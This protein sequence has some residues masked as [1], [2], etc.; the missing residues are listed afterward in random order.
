VT[1]L[2]NRFEITAIPPR[3]RDLADQPFTV[4]VATLDVA[5]AVTA[6]LMASYGELLAMFYNAEALE[7]A[8]P[9]ISKA[10]PSLLGS[11]R[12]YVAEE[13]SGKVIG[14]GGWSMER[15]GSCEVTPGMSHARHFGTTPAWTRQ[16]VAS[17]ILTRCIRDSET[18]GARTMEA[19]S[20]LAATGFYKK[21]GFLIVNT[22]DLSLRPGITLPSV[23]MR[24]H[25]NSNPGQ[26]VS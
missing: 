13:P 11:G 21:L 10:N 1:K 5:G 15:P 26:S 14:C 12:Y 8:L 9:L 24:R 25:L 4:R 20:T 6:V 2:S 18:R 3:E 19:Y 7:Q 23:H 22:I 16:G 17:A